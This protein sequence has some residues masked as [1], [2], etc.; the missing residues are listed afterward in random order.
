[1][2]VPVKMKSAF[3]LRITDWLKL[4]IILIV[5]YF[6]TNDPLVRFYELATSENPIRNRLV[7]IVVWG[8]SLYVVITAAFLESI[9]FRFAYASVVAISTF[10]SEVYKEVTNSALSYGDLYSLWIAREDY[11]S[12]ISNY[13]QTSLIALGLSLLLWLIMV[14]PAHSFVGKS[15]IVKWGKYGFMVPFVLV[16]LMVAKKGRGRQ[17]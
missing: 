5:I 10:T 6:T 4:A 8:I 1:M 7:F 12:A 11:K 13:W 16:A 15:R 2:Q 14:W 17:Q 3:A 9:L